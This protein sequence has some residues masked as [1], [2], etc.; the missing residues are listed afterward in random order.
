MLATRM[1]IHIAPIHMLTIRMRTPIRTLDSG[2]GITAVTIA[3]IGIRAIMRAGTAI[4]G[5]TVIGAHM[6]PVVDMVIAVHMVI[7]ADTVTAEATPLGVDLPDVQVD[8]HAGADSVVTPVDTVAAV[9]DSRKGEA[10]LATTVFCRDRARPIRFG[11]N[12]PSSR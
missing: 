6:G 3:A 1:C 8:L 4:A 2:V 9:T 7:E 5:L 11:I 10:C 12:S